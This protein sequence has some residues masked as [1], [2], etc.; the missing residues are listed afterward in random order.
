MPTA[1][2][3]VTDATIDTLR[4]R[5]ET[6]E[7]LMSG[8]RSD[9]FGGEIYNEARYTGVRGPAAFRLTG[10]YED[11]YTK[12]VDRITAAL[13]EAR[14]ALAPLLQLAKIAEDYHKHTGGRR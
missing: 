6:L 14:A 11:H 4:V 9:R 7:T 13:T 12:A 5:I 10:E 2:L 3:P 1:K 8:M